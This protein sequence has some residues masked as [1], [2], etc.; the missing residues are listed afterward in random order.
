MGR[1]RRRAKTKTVL[2]PVNK[3]KQLAAMPKTKK[4]N[5]LNKNHPTVTG[6]LEPKIHFMVRPARALLVSKGFSARTHCAF[7]FVSA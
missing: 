4:L 5:N 3:M 1:K 7:A 6:V 2:K